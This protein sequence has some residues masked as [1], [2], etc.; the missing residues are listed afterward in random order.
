M[1]LISSSI[2]CRT[3][4]HLPVSPLFLTHYILHFSLAYGNTC[5]PGDHSNQYTN[6][7]DLRQ[8]LL[9]EET[10]PRSCICLYLLL[11]TLTPACLYWKKKK[12]LH[13]LAIIIFSIH[14]HVN[15]LNMF[16]FSTWTCSNWAIVPKLKHLFFRVKLILSK[17]ST[18]RVSG[19]VSGLIFLSLAV[20]QTAHH[21]PTP[22]QLCL[23]CL[24]LGL[25]RLISFKKRI[26]K[27]SCLF[28]SLWHPQVI[29][30]LGLQFL[31]QNP[32][33]F[34]IKKKN[35]VYGCSAW[36]YVCVMCAQDFLVPREGESGIRSPGNRV[37]DVC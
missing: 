29:P 19:F 18:G 12:K 36:I 28:F 5:L 17:G 22:L 37:T 13:K 33:H 15:S 31:W 25:L 34:L 21:A 35:H 7:L 1:N 27:A 16:L 32:S 4:L 3:L 9:R 2:Q 26:F 14:S 30:V 8:F 24:S 20:F 10:F 11:P 23:L 6:M